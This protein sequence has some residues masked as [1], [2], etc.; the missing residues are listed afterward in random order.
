MQVENKRRDYVSPQR[1]WKKKKKQWR[2]WHETQSLKRQ[3]NNHACSKTIQKK[4]QQIKGKK[5][6]QKKRTYGCEKKK[7]QLVLFLFLFDAVSALTASPTTPSF[8]MNGRK[9]KYPPAA[10]VQA[11]R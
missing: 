8:W 6:D 2:E 5:D 3:W 4:K 11:R 1:K 10:S 9:G 7:M